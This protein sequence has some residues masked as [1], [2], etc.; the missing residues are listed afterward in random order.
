MRQA[1]NYAINKDALIKVAFSGYATPAQGPVPKGI[2][3]ST[4]Y[5]PW[6]YDVA[7]ARALLKE[8]GYPNGFST[9]L[10]S[11][12][13]SSTSQKV[14]QFVQQ[15]LNQLGVKTTVTAMD[16]GQ[17]VAQVESKGVKETGVRMFYSGWSASTGEADWAISPLFASQSAPPALFNTAFY[18]SPKVD[19]DLAAVLKTTSREEKARLYK[20]A[21]DTLWADAP[22]IFLATELFHQAIVR[23]YPDAADCGGAGVRV[24]PSVAGRSRPAGGGAGSGCVGGGPGTP[25]SW[26]GSTAADAVLALSH[27]RGAGRFWYLDGFQA[28]GKQRDKQP[29]YAYAVADRDQYG[30]VG[31]LRHVAGHSVR[32]VAQL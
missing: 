27:P 16:A 24:C 32:G 5:Q 1:L 11:Y 3:F 25:R 21:Q 13:N 15:Q 31:Y 10:W 7:K 23:A 6:P 26:V 2:D 8:A 20:D 4:Q 28:A 12:N 29:V 22:W 17:R 30:L 18:S 19:Q 9:T 14:L